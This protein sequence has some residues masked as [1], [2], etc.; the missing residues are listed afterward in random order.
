MEVTLTA[1]TSLV[2]ATESITVS[3]LS[4]SVKTDLICKLLE[5]EI[6]LHS[7]PVLRYFI[8]DG[9]ASP[10]VYGCSPQPCDCCLAFYVC[11]A[12]VAEHAHAQLWLQHLLV[13]PGNLPLPDSAL[14]TQTK[15]LPKASGH[16]VYPG[17]LCCSV[18]CAWL[19]YTCVG[20]DKMSKMFFDP[21][22]SLWV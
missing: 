5:S 1:K 6:T 18:V 19:W 2:H 7:I 14:P 8:V 9:G 21:G 15:H 17:Q 3:M 12:A 10:G 13:L 22:L 11:K 16:V 4:E 20:T